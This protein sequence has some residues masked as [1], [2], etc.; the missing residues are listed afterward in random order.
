VLALTDL[1]RGHLEYLGPF[2][3]FL[4]LRFITHHW[5]ERR[6]SVMKKRKNSNEP[7]VFFIS[8]F[9]YES[10]SMMRNWLLGAVMAWHFE[11]AG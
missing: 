11:R 3:H 10:F 1:G 7:V 6:K 9:G 5:H 2:A 4:S 8:H